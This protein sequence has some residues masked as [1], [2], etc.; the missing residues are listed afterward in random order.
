MVFEQK[1]KIGF[2]DLDAN[3]DVTLTALLKH[4]NQASWLHAEE[5]GC[6]I[7]K[8]FEI[9]LAFIIQRMGL[10]ILQLPTINQPIAVRTWPGEMTRSAFKRN[11]EIL[12]THGNKLVEWESL[13][14]LIDINER[15]IKRPSA[16][17][18]DIPLAGKLGVEVEA[19]KIIGATSETGSSASYNHTVQFNE[20]DINLHM[21]NAIYGD[22]V[23][24]VLAH[25]KTPKI[26]EWQE[27]QFNYLNEA[28]FAE[29]VTVS[30]NQ[31]DD[32]IY[33]TGSTTEKS[34]FIAEIKVEG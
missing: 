32:Q 12:D 25:T 13:W 14:V 30:Y 1:A 19:A 20:M 10:R 29:V 15:K 23:A 6:G 5:L 17:P 33:I 16:F 31:T 21:N 4:I 27:V 24:N 18:L 3:G 9:G 26:T 2:Y 28:K 8:T 22:L 7:E 34:V 11:G